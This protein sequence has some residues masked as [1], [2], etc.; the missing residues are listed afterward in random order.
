MRITPAG[1]LKK[2]LPLF[3]KNSNK[4]VLDYGAGNLRNSLYLHRRGYY[5]YAVD[6]PNRTKIN[7]LPRLKC[8][9]PD[10]INQVTSDFGLILCTFV[11]NLIDEKDRKEFLNTVHNKISGDG[12]LLIE[13]KGFSLEELDRIFLP[14]DFCR[15]HYEKG[16]YTVIVLYRHSDV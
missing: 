8:I 3:E 10:Q 12:Y 6:L 15:I 13:T 9:L 2:F 16:R 14:Q 11:L 5:V 7:V 4:V 1:S